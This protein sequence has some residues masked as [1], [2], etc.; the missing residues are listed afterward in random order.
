MPINHNRSSDEIIARVDQKLTDHM[1]HFEEVQM[2]LKEWQ[3][4]HEEW[5]KTNITGIDNRLTPIEHSW[6]TINRPAQW[7]ANGLTLTITGGLLWAGEQIFK[8]VIDHW[9]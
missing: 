3:E 9:K 2:R 1:Q 4:S 8:K 5:C 7:I 6:R